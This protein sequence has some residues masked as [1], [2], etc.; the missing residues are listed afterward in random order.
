MY[1]GSGSR[2]SHKRG[3]KA[4]WEAEGNVEAARV[5]RLRKKARLRADKHMSADFSLIAHSNPSSTGWQGRQLP[6]KDR[7]AILK[8]YT[9]SSIKELTA[10]F[11]L[12]QYD[13]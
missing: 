11:H 12:V 1:R 3:G 6:L 2:R 5:L 9:D 8:A 13:E 7:N 4:L 10:F